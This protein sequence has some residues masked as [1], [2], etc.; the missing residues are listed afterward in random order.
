M[1][2]LTALLVPIIVSAVVLF[3][4][5][6]I[7]WTVLPHHQGDF[8]KLGQESQFMD[9]VR[10]MNIPAGCYMFPHMTHADQ[11]DPERIELYKQGPRG[12]L[13]VWDFPNMGRNLGFTLLYF[14]VVSI[15]T[16]YIAWTGLGGALE[17]DRFMKAFQI[18][19]AIGVLVFGTSGLLNAVWFPRRIWTDVV[20]GIVYGILLGL[21]FGFF[22]PAAAVA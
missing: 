15:I 9:M 14:L 3:F 1:E 4:A 19:G 18:T 11:K 20:D 22:W 16:A 17:E 5:S 8:Q 7:A 13:V 2:F 12:K 21:I 6:F 10:Q